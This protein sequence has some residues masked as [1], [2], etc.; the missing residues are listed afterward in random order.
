M[1]TNLVISGGGVK[2][3][4]L[5][6][7]IDVLEQANVLIHVKNYIG[8]SIGSIMSLMLVCNFSYLEM[9]AFVHDFV[10]EEVNAKQIDINNIFGVF[11]T[12][13]LDEG[14]I[15]YTMVD[16]IL[17]SKGIDVNISFM[18]LTK[19]TGKNLIITGA[20]I[21]DSQYEYFCVDTTPDM[22]VKTAIRISTSYPIIFTPVIH[23]NKYYVDAGLYNNFPLEYFLNHTNTTIGISFASVTE[24]SRDNVQ[25]FESFIEYLI[26]MMNS[27]LGKMTVLQSNQDMFTKNI[28]WIKM[29]AVSLIN[30]N[31][32]TFNLDKD[33]VKSY[34]ETGRE[35]MRKFLNQERH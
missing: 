34:I 7:C 3:V 25:P 21:S 23:N 29:D 30:F 2:G 5:L 15:I 14:E 4:A 6:G 18:T 26:H 20:N 10:L 12:Y 32:L 17:T 35:Q 24:D 28:C 9:Y 16:K 11:T 27:V 33:M 13:G 22:S 8:C 31:T 1:Y 19:K